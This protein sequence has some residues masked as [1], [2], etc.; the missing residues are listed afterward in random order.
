[1]IATARNWN[2]R[3]QPYHFERLA[4]KEQKTLFENRTDTV[5]LSNVAR[6]GNGR[7]QPEARAINSNIEPM[8]RVTTFDFRS[9]LYIYQGGTPLNAFQREPFSVMADMKQNA[10]TKVRANLP[11]DLG[12][13]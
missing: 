8:E 1:M 3:Q 5:R 2:T 7:N 9:P 12:S 10:E 13:R 6:P 4:L 11:I